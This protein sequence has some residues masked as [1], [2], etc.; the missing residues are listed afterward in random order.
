MFEKNR[1]V[2]NQSAIRPKKESSSKSQAENTKYLVGE[3][4]RFPS[5]RRVSLNEKCGEGLADK[6]RTG[7]RHISN[8]E[9]NKTVLHNNAVY[10]MAIE[11]RRRMTCR[12]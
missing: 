10:D 8:R 6:I 12:P 1:A 3:K 11:S 5:P 7:G 4:G 2:T 9:N